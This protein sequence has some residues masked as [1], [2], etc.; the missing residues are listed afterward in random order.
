MALLVFPVVR[1]EIVEVFLFE[2][3]LEGTNIVIQ[4]HN[5]KGIKSPHLFE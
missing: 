1:F 2:E 5:A 3:T 4:Q